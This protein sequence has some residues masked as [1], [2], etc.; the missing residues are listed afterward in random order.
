MTVALV[1]SPPRDEHLAWCRRRALELV[2]ADDLM[3]AF[4]SMMH[5]LMQHPETEGLARPSSWHGGGLQAV[6]GGPN[7]VR[8]WI[9]GFR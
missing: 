7:C 6:A 1:P 3:G 5:D 4:A 8:K 2:E 9:E